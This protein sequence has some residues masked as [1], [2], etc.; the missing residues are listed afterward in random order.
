MI[1]G[2][3]LAEETSGGG[4]CFSGGGMLLKFNPFRLVLNYTK[5]ATHGGGDSGIDSEKK[6][7]RSRNSRQGRQGL[8]NCSWMDGDLTAR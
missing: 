8:L 6:R 4:G 3:G 5:Q 1:T 7:R 2:G